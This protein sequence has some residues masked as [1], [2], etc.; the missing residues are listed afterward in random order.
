MPSE[1][2]KYHE[3]RKQSTIA[4][5]GDPELEKTAFKLAE[6]SGVTEVGFKLLDQ[7]AS[8]QMTR[9]YNDVCLLCGNSEGEK[10]VFAWSVFSV[11]FQVPFT[12]LGDTTR[13]AGHGR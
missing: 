1:L 10:Q 3:I 5:A 8:K 4:D 12:E 6:W 13:I 7:A 2:L 11:L 9:N